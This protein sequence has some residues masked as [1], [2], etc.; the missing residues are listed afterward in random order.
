[1]VEDDSEIAGL[2]AR[3]LTDNGCRVATAGSG[4]EMDGAIAGSAPDLIVLDINLPEEDGL[5]I[6]RRLRA[7]SDVAII[8]LTAKGEEIDRIV[9]L[10]M[11][12]DDYLLKPFNPR[13]LLARIRAVMRR[14]HSSSDQ[15]E[16]TAQG[17]AFAGWRLDPALRHLSN[18][19]GAIVTLTGAEFDLLQAFVEHANRVL[20]RDQLLDLRQGRATS[21]P[22]DRSIDVLV[23]RLRQKLERNAREPEL[24]KTVRSGGYVLASAVIRG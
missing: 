16:R 3:Y 24:I 9:G 7:A 22:F 19:R 10:E 8:M 1:V 14:R 13:E 2:V 21:G 4:R 5:S 18:P 6:C 11:G 12:A 23:S 15:T 17:Y 20:S